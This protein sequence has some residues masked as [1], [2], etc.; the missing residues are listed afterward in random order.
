MEGEQKV[1]ARR[2]QHNDYEVSEALLPDEVLVRVFE[3]LPLGGIVAALHVSCRWH[4]LASDPRVWRR[5]CLEH[6]FPKIDR[7]LG[8]RWKLWVMRM[9]TRIAV[10]TRRLCL[11]RE[12]AVS[13]ITRAEARRRDYAHNTTT[14]ILV[15]RD[16]T[17]LSLLRAIGMQHYT[18]P[19]NITL[20]R[21]NHEMRLELVTDVTRKLWEVG[22]TQGSALAHTELPGLT[23]AASLYG[24][25]MADMPADHLLA[26]RF[27]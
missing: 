9:A 24:G 16:A 2:R 3:F 21:I 18:A 17:L 11:E 4:A 6:G 26:I 1:G 27:V 20:W 8:C 12:G 22:I 13:L 7:S 25:S 15:E 5:L 14:T 23:H 19:H 10:T